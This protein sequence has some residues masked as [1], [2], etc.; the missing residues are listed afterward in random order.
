MRKLK[1]E[2]SFY[3]TLGS[4][5]AIKAVQ[6]AVKIPFGRRPDVA[7]WRNVWDPDDL[8]T[9]SR[10]LNDITFGKWVD[11]T[12]VDVGDDDAHDFRRYLGHPDV[13]RR[14]VDA[15]RGAA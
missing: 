15:V 8:V 12:E 9:L 14:L 7:E 3:L 13:A 10:S 11:N 6:G 4:P 2:S 1:L 5:L